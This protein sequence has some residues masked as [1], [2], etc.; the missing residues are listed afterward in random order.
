M[1]NTYTL[2]SLF[3]SMSERVD[4]PEEL[5]AEHDFD[6]FLGYLQDVVVWVAVVP[7]TDDEPEFTYVSPGF[8]DIWDRSRD[9][10]LEDGDVFME[11]VHPDDR[12][13][14]RTGASESEYGAG[15]PDILEHRVVQPDGEIRW[16]KVQT[17]LVHDDMG[18]PAKRLGITVDITER[19]Q[20]ERELRRK[21]D[22]LE[23]FVSVVSH[24][25]RNPL[26]VA[27]G[28]LELAQRETDSEHLDAVADAHSRMQA[29]TDD[30]LTL[31]RE[32]KQIDQLK[33]VSLSAVIEACWQV[34]ETGDAILRIDCDQQFR[35]DRN[36]L[37]QLLENLIRNAVEHGG[38]EVTVRV[39]DLENGFY[40]AD[41]GPGIPED[42]REQVLE[43]GYTTRTNGTGFG[44]S[45]VQQIAN[46]HD[47]ELAVTESAEG[48]TRFEITGV[49]R[50]NN[51]SSQ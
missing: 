29:L 27:Q 3:S 5:L 28:Q 48:G 12:N 33:P 40:I 50:L 14:M 34:V 18:E 6:D 32:G 19:K 17:Y 35:A 13:H 51:D 16:V 24:D 23:N 36:R 2:G 49:Q 10:L 9:V 20:M 4:C 1:T 30:L 15:N 37:Q 22:Q 11:G 39:G 31:A 8:E 25:I 21:T 26:T 47:W 44:L 42:E 41:D 7:S 38:D 45:I 46:A 43:P